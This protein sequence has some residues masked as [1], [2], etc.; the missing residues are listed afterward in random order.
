MV[1]KKVC[2]ISIPLERVKVKLAY[3]SYSPSNELISRSC[4]IFGARFS[5]RA[6]SYNFDI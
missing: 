3:F 6:K 2:A 4:N 5:N 1:N